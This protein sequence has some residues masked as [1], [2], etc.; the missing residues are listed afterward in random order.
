MKKVLRAVVLLVPGTAQWTTRNVAPTYGTAPTLFPTAA[1]VAEHVDNGHSQYRTWCPD[2][3][4]AFGREWSHKPCAERTVPL[5]SCDYLYLMHSGVF[6][7]EEL[8]A[9]EREGALKIMVA[10]CSHTKCTQRSS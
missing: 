10:Y 8:A 3:V 1:E 9:E 4:E 5:L 2:C 7:R 6:G